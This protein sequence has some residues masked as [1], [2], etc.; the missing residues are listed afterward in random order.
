MCSFEKMSEDMKLRRSNRI[1]DK[2]NEDNSSS[3]LPSSSSTLLSS[4]SLLNTATTTN[5]RIITKKRKQES[6]NRN[7]LL[8]RES[9]KKYFK[10]YSIIIGVDEAGRG[11]SFSHSFSLSNSQD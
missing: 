6:K 1:K 4:S 11:S 3:S 5:T 8:T 7:I 2:Y 9:E 10:N